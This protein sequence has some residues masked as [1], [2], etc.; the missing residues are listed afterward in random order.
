VPQQRITTVE[1]IN[2]QQSQMINILALGDSYTIGQGVERSESWPH[3][4]ASQLRKDGLKVDT[5]QII[6]VT[7][8]TTTDLMGA[9][10]KSRLQQ[11]YGLVTLLIGVNDQFQG[12]NEESYASNFEKLLIKAIGF[13]GGRPNRV[14]VISI[15]D[16]GVT[17]FGKRFSSSRIRA[18]IDRFNEINKKIAENKDVRYVNVTEISRKAAED[19]T[20]LA[21]DSLHPSAKMY[22]EWVALIAPVAISALVENKQ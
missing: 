14:I 20:L 5:P 2:E 12:F 17:P 22:A 18:E 4:L 10:E 21:P 9:I 6:A 11:Q 8:W 1:P 15:P 16:Y 13:A 19:Q 7:G 3:Q